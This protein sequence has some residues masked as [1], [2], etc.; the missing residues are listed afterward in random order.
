MRTTL[1]A[2][3]L[4]AGCAVGPDYR[5]PPA[6]EPA[7]FANAGSAAYSA[8]PVRP[9]FWTAF[10]DALLA[11]LVTRARDRNHELRIALARLNEARAL[12]RESVYDAL[13]VYSA[14]AGYGETLQSA[15]QRPGQPR[16][17]RESA[18]YSGAF[19]AVWELDFFGR[20]RRGI[21]ASRASE[22]ALEAELR[23]VQV[24]VAAEIART[25]FELRATQQ[26]LAV[27]TRNAENQRA[28]LDYVEA[29][30]EAGRGTEFDQ[31]RARS[32]LLTTRATIPQFETA[33]AS[34]MH[35]LAVL[36]GEPPAALRD[37]LAPPRALPA[38]PRLTAIGDPA[39]LLRRRPDVRAAERRLAALTAQVGVAT[40]E[41]FPV[42]RF[43]GEIGFAVADADDAGSAIG[44]TWGF[45]PSL[46]WA[47]LDLGHVR[48]RIDRAEARADGAL[49]GYEQAVLR[50]L[51]ETENA[52]VA[53]GRNRER[54][55][56]LAGTV[57][58]TRRAAG[59]AELRYDGGA[60][61][62]L[63]V[64]DAQ[65]AQLEAEDRFVQARLETAASLVALYKALGGGW[66]SADTSTE[67]AAR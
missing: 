56:L 60:S 29:R 57:D 24:S 41:L 18:L 39:D 14:E 65:R 34:A 50:A 25:Y 59:F 27:A 36:V 10:D 58:A 40:A 45:G 32:Q 1:L 62:F 43:S 31:L 42:V 19:D 53:Y 5:Q 30:L 26:R 15:D 16:E 22:Q 38:L 54:L 47:G 64:L 8:E 48:A 55:E 28:T 44:E 2:A 13:P 35:R 37:R 46:S 21:E 49:A 51:E 6:P 20:V 63:D 67:T 11:E 9:R 61:D 4:L 52:L 7:A 12:R 66:D 23:D 3:A 17:T 33:V